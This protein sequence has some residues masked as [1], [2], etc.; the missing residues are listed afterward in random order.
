MA[1][2]RR[3]LRLDEREPPTLLIS[4]LLGT[5]T[6]RLAI[7]PA[8]FDSLQPEQEMGEVLSGAPCPSRG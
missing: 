7:A 6:K 1:G 8:G 4:R 2:S 3:L 5:T